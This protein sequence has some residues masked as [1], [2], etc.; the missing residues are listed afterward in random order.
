MPWRRFRPGVFEDDVVAH[1]FLGHRQ[2]IFNRPDAIRRVLVENSRNYVRTAPTVGV[3]SPL[4]GRGLFLS[5]GE[6]WK[7]QR[8]GDAPAFAP[9]AVRILARHVAAAGDSLVNDLIAMG[10]LRIDLVPV[11]QR[12]ALEII[13]SAMFSLEMKKHGV[14]MRRLIFR[15][16]ARLGRPTLLDFALPPV[17]RTF[18]IRLGEPRMVRRIG[19]VSTQ[20]ANPPPFRLQLR[21]EPRAARRVALSLAKVPS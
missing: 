14:E 17:V 1:R 10:K 19:I 5:T 4:F 3:L 18:W 11:L 6:E 13:G 9:R 16:A 12:L 15:Y 20:P 2:L 8:R 21:G 7:H